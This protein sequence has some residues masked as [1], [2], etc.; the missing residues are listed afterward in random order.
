MSGPDATDRPLITGTE[1]REYFH[2]ELQHVIDKQHLQASADATCYVLNV[3]TSFLHSERLFEHAQDGWTLKPL[4]QMYADALEAPTAD[5]RVALLRRLADVALFISGIF[6]DSLKHRTVDVNYYVAMGGSAYG[7]LSDNLSRW[8]R[9]RAL[10]SVFGELSG[11]FQQFVD[12]LN[13]VSERAHLNSDSDT[14][15]TYELWL[16]CGS[17]RARRRLIE[18]GLHPVWAP[19]ADRLQ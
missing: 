12:V 19:S 3:L 18:E 7:Y 17:T 16:K 13:E 1:L 10:S 15:R 6:S 4:A 2:E 5:T 9:G 11:K 8:A 14:L